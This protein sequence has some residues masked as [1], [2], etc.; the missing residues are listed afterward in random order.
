MAKGNHMCNIVTTLS[1]YYVNKEQNLEGSFPIPLVK[2]F[3]QGKLF[4]Y[5]LTQTGISVI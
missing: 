5:L 1:C 2:G 3:T 4:I